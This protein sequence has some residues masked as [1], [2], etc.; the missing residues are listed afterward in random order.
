LGHIPVPIRAKPETRRIIQAN[1]TRCHETTVAG[2]ADGQM[3]SGRFCFD[4]H[5]SV[6]H[7][8]RGI[9]LLPYQDKG[10]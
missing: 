2:V 3:D 10:K 7:G 1:C 8:E 4:C 9:S 5:R 6:A